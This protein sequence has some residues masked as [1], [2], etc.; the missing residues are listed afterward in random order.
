[1]SGDNG[2]ANNMILFNN[3]LEIWQQRLELAAASSGGGG[4][5]ATKSENNKLKLTDADWLV[6]YQSFDEW[7][8]YLKRG[9]M[10][11]GNPL[12]DLDDTK[13]GGSKSNDA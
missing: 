13:P 5:K 9:L 4:E 1:M 2:V 6:F 7:F 8:E 11:V 12:K 3:G 10:S